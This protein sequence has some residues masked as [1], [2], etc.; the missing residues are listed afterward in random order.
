MPKKLFAL[1]TYDV[2]FLIML[3]FHFIANDPARL[4]AF[5]NH[6]NAVRRIKSPA[7]TNA[8]DFGDLLIMLAAS[9]THCEM[10]MTSTPAEAG[11][12]FIDR[13]HPSRPK[14]S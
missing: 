11:Q 3:A 9:I 1:G 12:D 14:P 10:R 5:W 4:T 2:D 8:G 13:L 7:V 6:A